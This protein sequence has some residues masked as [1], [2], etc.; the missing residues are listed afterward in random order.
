MRF[1]VLVTTSLL[2]SAVMAQR[3]SENEPNNTSGT[4]QIVAIGSQVDGSL[5]AG[6]EDWYEFTSA[7]GSLRLFAHHAQ[8]TDTVF[9]LY[10]ASGSTLLAVNDDSDVYF[11]RIG[12]SVAAGT[13]QLRLTGWAPQTTGPYQLEIGQVLTIAATG[14]ESEPNNTLAQADALTGTDFLDG[15]LS[16]GADQ[17]WYQLTLTAPRTGVWFRI[18]EGAAPWVSNHRYEI[19]GAAGIPLLPESTFGQSS[20]NS[21]GTEI[22]SSEVR[23]WPAGTYYIVIRNS[24]FPSGYGPAVPQGNYRLE[25]RTMPMG[26]SPTNEAEPNNSIG[27]ASAVAIG[28]AVNGSISNAGGAD[29]SDIYGPINLSG[30]TVLQ[31]QTTQGASGALLDSTIRLLAYD[32]TVLGSWTYGNLLTSTSHA[33][34]TIVTSVTPETFYVEVTSPGGAAQQAGNYTLEIGSASAP[35]ALA[36]YSIDDVNTSC[37]GSNGLRTSFAVDSPGERPVLGT[38]FSRTVSNLPVN[39]P[40]F[41]IEGLS[42][43][44]SSGPPPLSLPFDL[45]PLGAPNCFVHVDP[46]ANQLILGSPSGSVTINSGM[47]NSIVFRGMAIYEQAVVLDLPANGLG[48]TASNY[49]RKSLGER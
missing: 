28:G 37:L 38:N 47:A 12:V 15:S 3:V 18:A 10:D 11:S 20:G 7:G 41:L 43:T 48:L 44:V 26:V 25:V 42:N 39:A 22:R 1:T 24:T 19:Y 31:F 36:S 30:P 16:S 14:S 8:Q 9:E 29:P 33:R 35:F 45:G 4:A 23:C 2:A 49:A 21:S 27:T 6:D 13:Y 40:F 17:D 34:A 32:G 46:V 5:T